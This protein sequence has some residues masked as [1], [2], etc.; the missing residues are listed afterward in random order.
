MRQLA[1]IES[2]ELREEYIK[3]EGVLDKVKKV[4]Y[5]PTTLIITQEMAANYYE[6]SLETI[7]KVIQRNN[8]ELKQDGLKVLK[9]KEFKKFK[10]DLKKE[11][12]DNFKLKD[13]S[14]SF[15]LITRTA[16]LRLGMLLRDSKVALEIRNYLLATEKNSLV[17]IE[18]L[19][20]EKDTLASYK[21][22]AIEAGLS[23]SNAGLIASS[24]LL[25]GT[26]IYEEIVNIFTQEKMRKKQKKESQQL[27]KLENKKRFQQKLINQLISRTVQYKDNAL[28]YSRMWQNLSYRIQEQTGFSMTQA[29]AKNKKLTYLDI[30]DEYD[31]YDMVFDILKDY[32]QPKIS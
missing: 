31:W 22:L 20:L 3:K 32:M 2:K 18:Q 29:K 30:I 19:M 14:T 17:S 23:K 9:K 26:S 28:E 13:K 12:N 15:T 6:V 25:N 7:K 10:E 16:L 8:E 11:T 4:S 27:E 1:L 24:A 21:K 5:I